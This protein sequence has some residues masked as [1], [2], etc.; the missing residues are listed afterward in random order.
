MNKQVEDMR[1]DLIEIFDKEY[2]ERRLIT[3]HNTAEKLTALGYRK[4]SQEGAECP[5]CHGTGRIGTTDW[6]TKNIS[7]EQLAKEKAKAVAE[8]EAQFKRNV[9]REIIEE[10]DDSLHKMAT[11]YVDAGHPIYFAICEMVHHKVIRPIEKKYES[12]G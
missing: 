9:A 11:E 7:K 3:P 1:G 6:L 4:A 12:E 2:D 10:I 5:T 8:H